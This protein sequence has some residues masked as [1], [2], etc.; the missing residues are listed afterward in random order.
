MFEIIEARVALLHELTEENT[1]LRAEVEQL[2][3][4]IA[5][6]AQ[7]ERALIIAHLRRDYLMRDSAPAWYFADVI[8]RCDH[9]WPVKP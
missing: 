4:K 6:S 3:S 7:S 2:R 9:H 5:S 1:K 8:E